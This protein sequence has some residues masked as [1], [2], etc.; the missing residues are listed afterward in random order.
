MTP[1]S[2]RLHALALGVGLALTLAP[3]ALRPSAA[4]AANDLNPDI[5]QMCQGLALI[6]DELG[7]TAAPGSPMGQRMQEELAMSAAQYGALWS[8]MKLT[9]T[10]TCTKLY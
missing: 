5:E 4:L 1:T 10:P 9:P 6:N 3:A 8:L 7:A 2:P